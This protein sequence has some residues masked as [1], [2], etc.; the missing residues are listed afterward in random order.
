LDDDFSL[1]S[2]GFLLDASA[3]QNKKCRERERAKYISIVMM[4]FGIQ[5]ER[6]K[7]LLQSFT[8]DGV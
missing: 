1:S 6:Q 2:S 8:I 7:P 3:E 4:S 5:E